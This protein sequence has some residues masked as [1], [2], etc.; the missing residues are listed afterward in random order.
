MARID[1]REGAPGAAAKKRVALP[2]RTDPSNDGNPITS[3]QPGGVP[4]VDEADPAL[5]RR[6]KYLALERAE[7]GDLADSSDPV[8][9]GPVPFKNLRR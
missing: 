4:I 1:D 9:D 7:S 6:S 5:G 2:K 3:S 8:Q